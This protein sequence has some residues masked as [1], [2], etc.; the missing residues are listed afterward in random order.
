[1]E[2]EK[3]IELKNGSLIFAK[4]G[5]NPDCYDEQTE[6]LTENGWKFFRSLSKNEKVMTLNQ[7][8]YALEWKLPYR[9][10]NEEYNGLMFSLNSGK[11]DLLVTPN[12]RFF[13]ESENGIKNLK[14]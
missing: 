13:I 3:Y 11:L 2:G 6:I 14:L 10:I 5:D 8:T 1:M 12:H 4:S 7:E 9:Y